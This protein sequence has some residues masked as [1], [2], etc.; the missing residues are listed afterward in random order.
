ML[1]YYRVTLCRLIPAEAGIQER[2]VKN[3]GKWIMPFTQIGIESVGKGRHCESLSLNDACRKTRD[4]GAPT[5][6][7]PY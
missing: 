1:A 3:I 6:D 7:A 2:Q 4:Y 5:R